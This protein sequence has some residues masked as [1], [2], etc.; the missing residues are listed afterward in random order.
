MSGVDWDLWLKM[1]TVTIGQ[2][3]ALSLNIDPDKMTHGDKEKDDFQKRLKLLTEIVFFMSN[4]RIASTNSENI[5]SEIY[6]ESFVE[7]ALDI[8]WDIP[9]ELK[10]LVTAKEKD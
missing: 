7:W 8:K 4:I 9:K 10:I 6:L 3:C 5:D 2:A 1:P